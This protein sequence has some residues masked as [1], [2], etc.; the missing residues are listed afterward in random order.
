MTGEKS[1]DAGIA[2]ADDR[3]EAETAKKFL[4][5]AV[6]LA[7]LTVL[8][9]WLCIR[10]LAP[11]P[12]KK[13]LMTTGS[14]MGAYHQVAK[15]YQASLA[16]SGIALELRTSAGSAENLKRLQEPDSGISVGLLQGGISD[17]KASPDLL[18]VGR[19]FYEPLWIFYRGA[20]TLDRLTQLKGKRVAIGAEG[21]GTQVLA[22]ALFAAS[23]ISAA[24]TDL[25]PLDARS[26]AAALRAGSIDAA[27]IVLAPE[28]PLIQEL[29]RDAGIR[30]MS[31]AQAEAMT[32]IMPYLAKVVLPQ[33]VIDLDR[34]IPAE[35]IALV[36]PVAALVARADV[37]PALVFLLAQ[38]ASE[39]HGQPALFQKAAE[40]PAAAD[41]EYPISEDAQRYY[42]SGPPFLQRY[43]PFWLAN[44]LERLLI[45]G[46]P[47]A[48]VL[49]PV[50]QVG[51]KVYQWRTRQRLLYWYNRLKR[52]ESSIL[53]NAS[54]DLRSRQE[55][56]FNRIE[57]AVNRIPDTRG[58]AEQFYNLRGHIDY[59]RGKMAQRS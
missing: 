39:T 45:F 14:E 47:I 54:P 40:F 42:K 52:L 17:E 46:L 1:I 53:S 22:K 33:G 48:T 56:E 19:V 8:T 57:Q 18:S 4:R 5:W 16:K 34:N 6:P 7:L 24:D 44:L 23:K 26:A 10:W 30:L 25:R 29:L 2:A 3:A 51:P 55:S 21:S 28:A 36:A 12:P 49:L 15:R 38:A 13:L 43:L 20:G 32:R 35:D 9:L 11:P 58:L 41:P 50:I 27:M 31:L 37:H 59:V